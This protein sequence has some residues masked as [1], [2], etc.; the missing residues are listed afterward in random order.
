MLFALSD[1]YKSCLYGKHPN[2]PELNTQ[3]GGN[4]HLRCSPEH[5]KAPL[6]WVTVTHPA[7]IMRFPDVCHYLE[8]HSQAQLPLHLH[9]PEVFGRYS[10]KPT[11]R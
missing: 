9:S 5:Q 8:M 11:P 3:V 6:G 7:K 1:W 2:H 10:D 4:A